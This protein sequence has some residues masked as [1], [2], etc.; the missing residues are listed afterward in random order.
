MSFHV[1]G[2]TIPTQ[3]IPT[4]HCEAGRY[5]TSIPIR[6]IIVE[7]PY[8]IV[9]ARPH[10][11]SNVRIGS[12]TALKYFRMGL[13]LGSPVAESNVRPSNSICAMRVMSGSASS[14]RGSIARVMA[15]SMGCA[16]VDGME[17]IFLT[18]PRDCPVPRIGGSQYTESWLVA[19]TQEKRT[20][21][22]WRLPSLRGHIWYGSRMVSTVSLVINVSV[23]PKR[24]RLIRK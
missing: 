17:S 18:R 13:F 10:G 16:R 6:S 15:N 9:S 23:A 22:C 11:V 5:R 8:P 3:S 2:V 19:G 21:P 14:P 20:Y 4:E 7:S 1:S 24:R 12:C